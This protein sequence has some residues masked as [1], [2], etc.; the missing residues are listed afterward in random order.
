MRVGTKIYE[1]TDKQNYYIL[2]DAEIHITQN[3]L[4]AKLS[5][6]AIQESEFDFEGNI[7]RAL[8]N[9]IEE[10][11]KYNG[12]SIN[13]NG[14]NCEGVAGKVTLENGSFY[15]YGTDENEKY[16]FATKNG[17]LTNFDGILSSS[18]EVSSVTVDTD[19]NVVTVNYADGHIYKYSSEINKSG[20][21]YNITDEKED[22]Q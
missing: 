20:N 17:G 11:K 9:K 1:D 4:F 5:A 22:F 18:K 12:V 19:K 16:G 14:L 21:V 3:G 7:T 2:S 8:K 10:N 15:F 13:K 6:P